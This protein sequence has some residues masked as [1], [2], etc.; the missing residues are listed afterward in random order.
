MHLTIITANHGT[1]EGDTIDDM[2]LEELNSFIELVAQGSMQFL[3][4][5]TSINPVLLLGRGLI[6]N[7]LSRGFLIPLLA[8]VWTNTTAVLLVWPK[9]TTMM[10]NTLDTNL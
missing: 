1:F 10:T 9:Y 3:I 8:N 6:V 7:L 2:S 4:Q 5:M